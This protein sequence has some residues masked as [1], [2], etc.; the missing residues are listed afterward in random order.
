MCHTLFV[1]LLACPPGTLRHFQL[2]ES[3]EKREQIVFSG[4]TGINQAKLATETHYNTAEEERKGPKGGK[5]QQRAKNFPDTAAASTI[6]FI[7]T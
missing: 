2:P 7:E 5:G 3:R 6:Y 1:A 4:E